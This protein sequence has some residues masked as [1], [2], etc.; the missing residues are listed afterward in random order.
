MAR[1]LV[2]LPHSTV[3]IGGDAVSMSNRGT[4]SGLGDGSL[5]WQHARGL[6]RLRED[7]R[8]DSNIQAPPLAWQGHNS[9]LGHQIH[10]PYRV[11]HLTTKDSSMRTLANDLPDFHV[12]CIA[13]QCCT[14]N[15]MVE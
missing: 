8:L 11:L 4:D 12:V 13:A 6:A 15:G 2:P 14:R 3:M 7:H 5:L 10:E 9:A 1:F